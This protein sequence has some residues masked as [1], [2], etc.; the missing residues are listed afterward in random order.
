M[1]KGDYLT[2]ARDAEALAGAAES[3]VARLT[4]GNLARR[5]RQLAEALE[6]RPKPDLD[7]EASP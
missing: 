6:K 5:Y 4:W 1:D 3:P 7:G 2:Q